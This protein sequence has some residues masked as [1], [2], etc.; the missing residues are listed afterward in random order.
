MENSPESALPGL[1]YTS[2]Q[3]FFIRFAQFWCYSA[4]PEQLKIDVLTDSH[5]PRQFRVIGTLRNSKEFSEAFSCPINSPM[6]PDHK[7][8]VW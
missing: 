5:S 3:I 7:C 1:N 4:T 8:E 2:V 6:N